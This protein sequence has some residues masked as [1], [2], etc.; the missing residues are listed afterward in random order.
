MEKN[1][2]TDFEALD[3][4]QEPSF[5]HYVK[6]SDEQA[7]A[8][9]K[10]WLEE[11]PEK[12]EEVGVARKLVEAIRV[13]ESPVADEQINQLWD[14]IQTKVN[15]EGKVRSL[16]S[17]NPAIRRWIGIAAAACIGLLF[18]FY[19]Y[20]PDTTINVRA[21]EQLVYFLPDSSKITV[22]AGSVVAFNAKKWEEDRKVE[23]EGEAFF[24]VK[25]GS[26]FQVHT[27]YGTVEVLGT[28][29]NVY[30]RPDA[31]AVDCFTGKVRVATD[32]S[33]EQI[34]TPGLGTKLTAQEH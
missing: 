8:F 10:N 29:F 34:L 18:F 25:K 33:E 14:K 28:S 27:S 13:K 23:L 12:A 2:Y 6:G 32:K 26:R 17:R 24:E 30:A 4:A 15:Q 3:F 22:N 5:I 21:A 1:I 9:W 7:V 11:H 31:F 20:N 16:P 19:Q